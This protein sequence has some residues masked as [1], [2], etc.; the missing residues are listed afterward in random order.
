MPDPAPSTRQTRQI[1]VAF[2]LGAVALA[3]ATFAP[4]AVSAQSASTEQ[5]PYDDKLLRLSEILGAV[6]FL[7]ELCGG[8]DQML[9]RDQMS[10]LINAEASSALR[11]VRLTR[12]FNSGYRSYSRTYT[13][14]TPTAQGAIT[15]FIT[16]AA[17]ISD[18]LVKLP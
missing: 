7:R 2:V 18:A 13:S 16:E 17:E 6:H 4:C 9:W 11:R 14:C 12:A 15:R 3:A 1:R 8:N 10:E 5:R